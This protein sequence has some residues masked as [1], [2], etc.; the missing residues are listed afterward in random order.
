MGAAEAA[1][2]NLGVLILP[3]LIPLQEEAGI[4]LL[5]LLLL[6]FFFFTNLGFYSIDVKS[7]SLTQSQELTLSEPLSGISSLYF[8]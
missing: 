7:A 2:L 8:S 3:L 4:F 6:L 1:D 5:L